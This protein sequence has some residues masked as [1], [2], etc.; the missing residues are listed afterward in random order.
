MTDDKANERSSMWASELDET[1]TPDSDEMPGTAWDVESIRD[2]WHP[3]SMRLPP[4]LQR[5]FDT[6]YKRLD[7][8]LDQTN[9]DL[10]FRKDRHFKPLVIALGLAAL[11]GKEPDDVVDLISQLKTNQIVD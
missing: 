2:T 11:Q 7:L 3:N 8:Q 5:R 6:R 4:H 10:D 9:P 1:E